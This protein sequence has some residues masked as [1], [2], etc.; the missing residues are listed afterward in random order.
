MQNKSGI[1]LF[2][3][4]IGVSITTYAI[5]FLIFGNL[6]EILGYFLLDLAFVPFEIIFVSLIVDRVLD[7]MEKTKFQKKIYMVIEVFFSEV[8]KDLL[9]VFARNDKNIEKIRDILLKKKARAWIDKD[10]DLLLKTTLS[11]EHDLSF[12]RDEL[13]VLKEELKLKREFLTN[14]IANSL[15]L[16]HETFSNLIITVFHLLEELGARKDVMSI[17]DQDKE[18]LENDIKRVHLLLMAE[19]VMYMKHLNNEYPFQF[20]FALRSNPFNEKIEIE[21]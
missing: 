13:K 11:Y 21:Y 10:F 12:D 15:I 1:L 14:M 7:K 4:L 3:S 6:Q 2:A 17:S 19:W 9:C 16:E 20:S 8:G 18:H 5:H